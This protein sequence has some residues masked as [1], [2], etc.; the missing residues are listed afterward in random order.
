[1]YTVQTFFSPLL[2]ERKVYYL[3]LSLC[4]FSLEKA[5]QKNQL[6]HTTKNIE[7]MT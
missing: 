5:K 3:L 6:P 1:M 2:V 4:G 7:I